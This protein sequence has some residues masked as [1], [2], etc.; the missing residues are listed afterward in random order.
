MISVKLQ[1]GLGNLLFQISAIYALAK[2]NNAEFGIDFSNHY[3][4]LQG[5]N[6]NKY[7][8]NIL[9][10]VPRLPENYKFQYLYQEPRHEYDYLPFVDNTIYH[11]YYQS[12]K[13]WL[14]YKEE[15]VNLFDVPPIENFNYDNLTAVHVRHGD[16]FRFPDTHPVCSI[17]YYENCMNLIGCNNKFIFVSDDID[18]CKNNFIDDKISFS[19]FNSEIDD[20]RLIKHCRNQ[21]ISNSTYSW[22]GAYLNPN[23]NKIVCSPNYY[24]WFGPKGPKTESIIP[25]EFTQICQ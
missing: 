8:D 21:I 3:L 25:D 9:K 2:R 5:S 23:H 16:Y 18:W 13:Y 15:I 7:A 17:S 20:L 24:D 12:E 10:N 4:P 14:D 1:G 11:G 22:W 6:V 19:S